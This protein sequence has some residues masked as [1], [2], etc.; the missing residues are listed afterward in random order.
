MPWAV[1]VTGEGIQCP[2]RG[3]DQGSDLGRGCYTA[4]TTETT[5]PHAPNV[6]C[7]ISQ[8]R[9]SLLPAALAGTLLE[10]HSPFMLKLP[11]HP[12]LLLG[13][14][15][16]LPYRVPFSS[17]QVLEAGTVP[18][19]MIAWSPVALPVPHICYR[20]LGGLLTLGSC[21]GF[22]CFLCGGRGL[23]LLVCW[24]TV[25]LTADPWQQPT[26]CRSW[27]L[28]FRTSLW[29]SQLWKIGGV[30]LVRSPPVAEC[31]RRC[32]HGCLLPATPRPR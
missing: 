25:P 1:A 14:M 10:G 20:F 17:L 19:G 4:A 32:H 5:P 8:Q 29:G 31:A 12:A 9:G 16:P 11:A 2:G 18:L 7:S 15:P 23:D 24:A 3:S 28:V 13:Y 6:C 26:A 30:G 27:P 21:L 22:G